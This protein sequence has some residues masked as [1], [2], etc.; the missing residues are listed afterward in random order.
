MKRKIQRAGLLKARVQFAFIN[1]EQLRNVDTADRLIEAAHTSERSTSNPPVRPRANEAFKVPARTESARNY[2]AE[3][4]VDHFE[5]V[6]SRFEW[7][8]GR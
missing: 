8:D 3:K 4:A 7:I 1:T 2:P 5:T 6:V